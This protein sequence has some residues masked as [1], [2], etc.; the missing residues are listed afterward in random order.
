MRIFHLVAYEGYAEAEQPVYSSPSLSELFGTVERFYVG[1]YASQVSGTDDP[2]LQIQEEISLD[3]ETWTG[4]WILVGTPVGI[5]IPAGVETKF[6]GAD[7]DPEIHR[8]GA[9]AP[10]RR[11]RILVGDS[12]AGDAKAMVRVWVTGRDGS[13]RARALARTG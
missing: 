11:L 9:K 13:P 2:T 6:Q 7:G 5:P 8:F 3:G 1:G 10:F 12:G 4:G